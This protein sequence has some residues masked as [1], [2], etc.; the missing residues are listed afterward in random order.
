MKIAIP[1]F[2][3]RV[4]PRFDVCPEVWIVELRG[5]NVEN[6][7]RISMESLNLQQRLNHL[8]SKGVDKLICG[9]IDHFCID[10]LGERGIEVIHNVAG[11]AGEVL[12]LFLK[13]GLRSGFYCQRKRGKELYCW[14]RGFQGRRNMNGRKKM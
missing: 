13:G 6:E 7:E 8:S 10:R 14:R 4:S 5:G 2:G 12:A 11:E 1:I 9:G 3:S